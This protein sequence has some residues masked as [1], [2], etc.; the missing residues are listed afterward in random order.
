MVDVHA[1]TSSNSS[2]FCVPCSQFIDR[3]RTSRC[4]QRRVP[5]VQTAQQTGEILQVRLL[6]QVVS[7][8][9][10]AVQTLQPV[11]IPQLQF[12][13]KFD[14]PVVALT[15]VLVGT[16]R[17][18]WRYRSCRSSS[19]NGYPSLCNDRC[20]LVDPDSAYVLF[21]DKVVLPV[22]MQDR[23]PG[24]DVQK[25][26]GFPQLQFLTVVVAM[27][28]E[29]PQAQFLDKV[30]MSIVVSGA[31]GQTV[32]KTCGDAAVAVLGQ[33]VHALCSRCVWCR[34]PDSADNCGVSTVTVLGQG[35]HSRCCCVWCRWPDS[36]ENCGLSTVAV[37][38]QGLFST[39]L[40]GADGQT[41]QKPVEFPQVQ[42]LDKVDMPVVCMTGA[43]F[44]RQF[45][46][47]LTGV[48]APGLGWWR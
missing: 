41:V 19:R 16:Y 25:T 36:A 10:V 26:V 31:V 15:V 6:D 44:S 46:C 42:F 34:R 5:S 9:V 48:R 18:L 32:Q 35:L 38:G 45:F 11:E 7:M 20:W 4:A 12:L 28:V 8:P 30:Y 2:S 47:E 17:K 29:I 39:L 3:V 1:A 23:F 37:P 13:D 24:L 21:L 22:V 14:M 27:P 40:S 33:V 43:G